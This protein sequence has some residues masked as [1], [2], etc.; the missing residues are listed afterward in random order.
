MWWCS[1]ELEDET[2]PENNVAGVV[3]ASTIGD[4]LHHGGVAPEDVHH[5]GGGPGGTAALPE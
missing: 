2:H 1:C 5:V 4:V 3:I